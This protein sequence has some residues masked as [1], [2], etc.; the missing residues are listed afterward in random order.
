MKHLIGL[1]TNTW[2]HIWKNWRKQNFLTWIQKISLSVLLF[3]SDIIDCGPS[4]IKSKGI[5][6]INSL[7]IL[8][9]WTDHFSWKSWHQTKWWLA[10]WIALRN[11]IQH[12]SQVNIT[13][14]LIQ[15]NLWCIFQLDDWLKLI[16]F[17]T[18]MKERSGETHHHDNCWLIKVKRSNFWPKTTTVTMTD[19]LLAAVAT[20]RSQQCLLCW[21]VWPGLSSHQHRDDGKVRHFRYF[22]I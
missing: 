20:V 7:H 5:I 4:L 9:C 3:P 14:I 12:H 11:L 22:N 21:S 2:I 10:L 15:S 13:I 18:A 16:A 8:F 17:S 1:I 6:F 19:W